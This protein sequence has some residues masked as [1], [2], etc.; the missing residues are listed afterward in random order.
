[1]VSVSMKVKIYFVAAVVALACALSVFSV[2]HFQRKA[3]KDAEIINA[4][5]R[6]RMLSQVM[7]KNALGYTSRIEY[8]IMESQVVNLNKYITQMRAVYTKHMVAA[9]DNAGLGF[10]MT[11]DGARPKEIPFPATFTRLVNQKFVEGS[12]EK[13][14][15]IDI[16]SQ[17][18]VN[19]DKGLKSA[20]DK[21]ADAFLEKNLDK[22]Y[23]EPSA[24]GSALYLIF[25]TADIATVEA[26]AVCHS[27]FANRSFKVG[28]MLGIRKFTI[29][30]A[31]NVELG[32]EAL[33]G[34]SAEFD[35]AKQVFEK[36]LAAMRNGG[37]YPADMEMKQMRS[38]PPLPQGVAQA[39]AADVE[40]ELALFLASVKAFADSTIG[41]SFLESRKELLEHS[42]Q[43]KK[44]SDDLVVIYEEVASANQTA[45]RWSVIVMGVI[46]AVS[47]VIS[48]VFLD[49]N[50]LKPLELV[51]DRLNEG[52]EQI[53]QAS[54][55][56]SV[57]S[58]SLAEGSTQQASSLQETAAA[59]EQIA[60]Q[61][62]RNADNAAEANKMAEATRSAAKNG[63]AVMDEMKVAMEAI[64]GSSSQISKIIKVIEE[65]AF[66]TNL[67][68]LNAAVEAAR[69]GEHGKGFAVVAEE[70]RNLAQRSSAAAKDTAALIDQA[71]RNSQSGAELTR[72][73]DS[74]LNDIVSNVNKVTTFVSDIHTS[75]REQAEGVGQVSQA[76]TNVD[77][78]T[79]QNAATA[80]ETAASAEQ[81]QAQS[82]TMT[83]IAASLMIILH[84]S[85]E[86]AAQRLMISERREIGGDIAVWDPV[87]LSVG[88][89]EMDT[90]HK[91]I[92]D[93]INE[94]N[95][96]VGAG[97]SR[98]GAEV[99]V[100]GLV[101]Y[102]QT[103]LQ[104]EEA[105]LRRYQ[106][107]DYNAHKRIHEAMLNKLAHLAK[108]V[109]EGKKGAV[110]EV[111]MF[112]KDWL[113]NHIQKV[114][115]KYGRYIAGRK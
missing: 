48:V 39:K 73:A 104:K 97:A 20:M 107:P 7:A 69:A 63:S 25:Y 87:K 34:Q 10:T 78:I 41:G 68:A 111:M 50:V 53:S 75:S 114:D 51:V 6:Q 71:V 102:A 64:G 35:R 101:E 91:R 30:F 22:L 60:A 13:G 9:V 14:M 29:Y 96:S 95:K 16:L 115:M 62:Q 8:K 86:I 108:R 38:T 80:E 67:L 56:V 18:P 84:G 99:A 11:P 47:I 44:L 21:N 49:L 105:M 12:G 33:A 17:N 70:V 106:Y 65:I 23:F 55:E 92:L 61:A 88:I 43:M 98:A 83:E 90:Q 2:V 100:A 54:G 110:V 15:K 19:P 57:S 1:M 109:E 76:I 103:H 82:G 94:L 5:G 113:I 79:Q 66:Q 26:C 32:R 28:D 36:T 74:A 24:E 42:T 52:A 45:I 112:V 77:G 81:M 37:E 89:A 31:A 4:L 59:V 72:K 85:E 3:A 93:I 40:R 27:G 46:I 58:Q